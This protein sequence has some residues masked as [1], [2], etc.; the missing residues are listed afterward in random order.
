MALNYPDLLV[1]ARE[2]G[3]V[4]HYYQFTRHTPLSYSKGDAPSLGA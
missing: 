2:G 4:L 3:G 1:R